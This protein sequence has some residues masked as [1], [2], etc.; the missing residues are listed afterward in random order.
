MAD[1]K[2]V[3]SSGNATSDAATIPTK[4]VST[5]VIIKADNDSTPASGDILQVSLMATAGDPDGAS[6]DEFTTA[7]AAAVLVR[8]D[9]YDEDPSISA[10]IDI[11]S[12]CKDIKLYAENEAGAN[13]IT[14]SAT[15]YSIL[16]DETRSETQIE[17]T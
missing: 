1:S 17:W 9:T 13:D 16:S 5:I 12:A 7:G 8:L 10:P 3:T 6:T 15:M 11:P 4:A 14:V 2:S